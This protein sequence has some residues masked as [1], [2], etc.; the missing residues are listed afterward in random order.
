MRIYLVRHA[1]AVPH[2]TTGV[3]EDDRPLT[4]EGIR[5]MR[6]AAAGLKKL[7]VN[8]DLIVSSPLPRAL[9]T[10]EIVH[11]VLESSRPIRKEEVLAPAGRPTAVVQMVSR[12][13]S[14]DSVMMVGHQPSLGEIASELLWGSA[15]AWLD[16]KKGGA[17]AIDFETGPGRPRGTLLWW[18][19][20][21]ILRILGTD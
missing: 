13:R 16:L 20:P 5:K 19:T 9:Q 18:L 17:C 12:F 10:A 21:K 3:A 15:D 2:G 1:I 11:S 14:L 8:P 4:G 6:E 7:G